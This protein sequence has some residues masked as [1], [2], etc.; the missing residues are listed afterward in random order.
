MSVRSVTLRSGMPLDLDHVVPRHL[1]GPRHQRPG[2]HDDL[3]IDR[4]VR[5][6]A[7]ALTSARISW[8]PWPPGLRHTLGA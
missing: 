1:T 7:S 8:C 2:E 4:V 3:A 5:V 6:G